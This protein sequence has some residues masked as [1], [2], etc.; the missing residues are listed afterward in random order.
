MIQ[1][2][3]KRKHIF[4]AVLL[5]ADTTKSQISTT[6][7]MSSQWKNT[8][9]PKCDYLLYLRQKQNSEN[10]FCENTVDFLIIV[11]ISLHLLSSIKE[12]S[13]ETQSS[14]TVMRFFKPHFS[15]LSSEQSMGLTT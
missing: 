13:F 1:E 12:F 4:V 3:T 14:L 9:A 2:E 11:S 5:F 6:R 7:R 15:C 10:V 8:K